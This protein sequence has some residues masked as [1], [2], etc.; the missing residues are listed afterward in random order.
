[1]SETPAP[2][3]PETAERYK[4]LIIVLTLI[5]TVITAVVASL[6]ADAN[7]RANNANRDSQYYALLVS[8]EV[9][10]SGLQSSYDMNTLTG[11]VGETQMSLMM[12]FTSMQS[13]QSGDKV[14]VAVN[15][16]N[17]LRAQARADAL[18]KFSIFY[19][20]PRYAPKT[21][22]GTPNLE[23]YLV[24]SK[25]KAIELT[26]KQNAASDAYHKW[27]SK[28]DS[29]VGVLTVIAVAFFLLG[30]AQALSGPMRLVFAIFG[31]V[32]LLFA[33]GWTVLILLG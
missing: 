9:Y 26:Q 22:D 27:S 5:T 4:L 16:I 33:S 29:Y 31:V 8:G 18:Q 10:R 25:A 2:A 15:D 21:T 6:Q 1:M 19:A 17:A 20:D 30:L 14:G 24:D 7:I 28:S 3:V 12:Q 23:A 13:Q 11:M 32:I